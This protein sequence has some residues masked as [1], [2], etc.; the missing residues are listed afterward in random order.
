MAL[1]TISL[2][3]VKSRNFPA[4]GPGRGYWL[5]A[6]CDDVPQATVAVFGT[7]TPSWKSDGSL[8]WTL[9]KA[10]LQA[11]KASSPLGKLRVD[12]MAGERHHDKIRTA[13]RMVIGSVFLDAFA[14][15]PKNEMRW[16]PLLNCRLPTSPDLCIQCERRTV[17]LGPSES[18]E[19]LAAAV[20]AGDGEG[21]EEN[22]EEELVTVVGN[23]EEDFVLEFAAKQDGDGAMSIVWLGRTIAL[24]QGGARLQLRSSPAEL[25]AFFA[26]LVPQQVLVLENSAEISL[27]GFADKLADGEQKASLDME[28][29]VANQNVQLKMT[30]SPGSTTSSAPAPSAK[31]AGESEVL[32]L[33]LTIQSVEP[34]VTPPSTDTDCVISIFCPGQPRLRFSPPF[35]LG[36]A[37]KP[38]VIGEDVRFELP[39][40]QP[41]DVMPWLAQNHLQVELMTGSEAGFARLGRGIWDTTTLLTQPG[42]ERTGTVDIMA[43]SDGGTTTSAERWG[44]VAVALRWEFVPWNGGVPAGM[45]LPH[46]SSPD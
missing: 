19:E 30:L 41:T 44:S 27:Q 43:S 42:M 15:R 18:E 31:A 2:R 40:L 28:L 38:I 14:A 24:R 29:A 32:A 35:K 4:A 5:E 34:L 36:G 20:A 9:P 33:T 25:R 6:S 7:T 11:I 23:G 37:R 16:L 12:C 3:C 17:T 21:Q 39:G 46:D 22:E 13:S 10:R 26:N 45:L 8:Q 1:V